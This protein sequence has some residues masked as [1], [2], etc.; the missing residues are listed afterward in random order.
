MLTTLRLGPLALPTYPLL[1]IFGLYAGL[2]LAARVAARRGLNPDHLYN[3]G[4][5]AAIVALIAGRLGHVIRFLPAYL[6]DPISILSPN[7]AAFEPLAAVA[8]AILVFAW[9]IR[10]YRL[11][12][13]LVVDAL[14]VG[15]LLF[16]AVHALAEGLN[17]RNFGMPSLLPWA[18]PQ[19]DVYRHPV[20]F[21]EILG[22]LGAISLL[23]ALLDRL[24]PGQAALLATAGYAAV[25]L[26]VDAFRDQPVTVGD[27]LRLTQVLAWIVLLL[28][29]AGLYQMQARVGATTVNSQ[30]ATINNQ[31]STSN[32]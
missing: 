12:V 9:Y 25:R 31:Q 11:P 8:A 5:S 24:R 19:W 30:Q 28:A 3:A 23:W 26:L 20:Q 7:L 18:I 16:L 27:G 2:W 6:T 4:F 22:I 21:Y 32:G 15:S 29:L 10:R 1:I 14:A 17:G 13:L